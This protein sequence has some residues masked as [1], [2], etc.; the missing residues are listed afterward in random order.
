MRNV[1]QMRTNE[2][3]VSWRHA[4]WVEAQNEREEGGVNSLGQSSTKNKRRCEGEDLG[5]SGSA[6]ARKRASKS[7]AACGE[8][9]RWASR[10]RN[11]VSMYKRWQYDDVLKSWRAR[12]GGG[13][14]QASTDLAAKH[15][16][17]C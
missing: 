8:L 5:T 11:A 2:R 14:E 12:G 7:A 16:L 3:D 6:I 10:R 17:A 9:P 15:G 13:G 4:G 1:Y